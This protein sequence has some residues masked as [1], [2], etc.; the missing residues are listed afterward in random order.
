MSRSL[1]PAQS[2]NLSPV[3]RKWRIMAER[4]IRSVSKE[5]G[6][7]PATLSRVERGNNCDAFTLAKI[8]SWLL[9]KDR[10]W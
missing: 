6:I 7:S 3:L 9:A 5:I 1:T 10:R 8:L 4:G 2:M